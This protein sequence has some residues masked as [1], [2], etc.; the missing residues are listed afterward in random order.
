MT[1]PDH[2]QIVIA[3]QDFHRGGTERVAIDLA[4]LW[5]EAGR[6][7]TILCGDEAGGLRETV[8]PRVAVVALEP[9][10]RRGFL[11]RFALARA[12]VAWIGAL[13]PDAI[14]LPGNH[15]LFLANALR[16]AVPDA[17]TVLKISNPLLPGRWAAPLFRHFTRG[18]DGF[19]AMNAGLARDVTR[20]LPGRRV[21][22]LYDPVH[23]APAAAPLRRDGVLNI[24]WIGRLEP[25]KDA[26]LALDVA[27]ALGPSAHLAM[28]GDGAQAVEIDRR[29]AREA[30][31][32][33]RMGHVADIAPHLAGAD[34]LLITS[35]YEGGPAVA[36]EA[37][38]QG[39]P[40]VST[41]CSHLL[42][43]IM[44][45]PKAG[46]IV[47][48]RDPAALAAALRTV[49]HPP[50]EKLKALVMRFEPR[51][52]AQAYLDFFDGLAHDA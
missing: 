38:A 46:R 26:G 51:T 19:A 6:K 5:T 40:V 44:T 29:I 49:G 28:L 22:T 35:R 12:M 45:I 48:S 10:V 30:L 42:R 47:S 31:P 37:L 33:M 43:E 39:V 14:F 9:R 18:V 21:A 1:G 25:Q 20:L 2:F 4:R 7:V 16:R 32:V 13:E 3:L 27:R 52:C 24:L 17:A 23:V 41:D 50:L 8:D 34:A 15:H 36:V 11:S